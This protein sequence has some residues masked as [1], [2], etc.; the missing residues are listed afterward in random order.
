MHGQRSD[1]NESARSTSGDFRH[2]VISWF[3]KDC[4]STGNH[5]DTCRRKAASS[6]SAYCGVSPS[7]RI[8]IRELRI[9]LPAMPG[10]PAAVRNNDRSGPTSGYFPAVTGHMRQHLRY[11][12]RFCP[13]NC[14]VL[15][16][17]YA[18]DFKTSHADCGSCFRHTFPV[19]ERS[20]AVV[21]V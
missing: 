10:S 13:G 17:T 16:I 14:H 21:M 18:N 8:S 2:T 15:L 3:G 1:L 9:T 12:C 6:S 20:A 5:Q 19:D 7:F 11:A 4:V